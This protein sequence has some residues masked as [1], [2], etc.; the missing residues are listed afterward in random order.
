MKFHLELS[1]LPAPLPFHEN[2]KKVTGS[3]KKLAKFCTPVTILLLSKNKLEA[4]FR[5]HL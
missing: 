2:L 1:L 4:W 5:C 3:I